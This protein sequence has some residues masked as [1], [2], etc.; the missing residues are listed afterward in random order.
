MSATLEELLSEIPQDVLSEIIDSPILWAETLLMTPK[1]RVPFEANF[2]QEQILGSRRRFNVIRVHRRAGKSYALAILA[3]HASLTRRG[4]EVLVIAPGGAQIANV[5]DTIRDFMGENSWMQEYKVEDRRNLPQRISF[6]NG[7]KI[8]G[9]T[10]A[11]RSKGQAMTLRGQGADIVLIDEGAYLNEDDW[12]AITPIMQGDM[13]RRQKTKVYIASTPAYTRGKYYEYCTEPRLKKAWNEIFVPID[14]NPSVTAE[15]VEECRST[16]TSEMEWAREYLAQFPELGEGVFPKSM[17]EGC[18]RVYSYAAHLQTAREQTMR[19]EKPPVR[20]IG[21]D[22]DKYNKDGHGPTIVVLETVGSYRYRLIYKEEIPQSSFSLTN[23]VNRVI[24]LNEIFRPEWIYVDRGYGDM[25]V[26]EFHKYGKQFPKSGLLKKVV[27]VQFGEN[28]DC[29]MPGGGYEKKRFKQSMVSLLRAWF[30]RGQIE[31]P[32]NDN[33]LFKDLIEYHVESQTE[34]NIKYSG[35]ND[36]TIAAMGLA[37]MA[38]HQ[39]CNNPYAPP[40]ATRCYMIAEQPIAVPSD[41]LRQHQGTRNR[42]T[43]GEALRTLGES[44]GGFSRRRLGDAL[45]TSRNSF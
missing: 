30:E 34:N 14:K 36:H 45:P 39:K 44:G 15:F 33:R 1:K 40:P 41:V 16:C 35:E 18:Q 6:K 21:V 5:F 20:T 11:A 26:E 22:W 24:E 12:P 31:I 2:V 10:T 4:T 9:F 3:L 8:Q 17:V 25:Q 13:N 37:A 32:R 7:S 19:R 27:G 28:V 29:P 38:M 43:M 42:A 23:A